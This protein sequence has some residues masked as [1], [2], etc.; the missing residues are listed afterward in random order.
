M[1]SYGIHA[2]QLQGNAETASNQGYRDTMRAHNQSVMA[3]YK[4]T[5]DKLSTGED[6]GKGEFG[7]LTAY[8]SLSGIHAGYQAYQLYQKHGSFA[9]AL[10]TGT[11]HNI[12]DLSGGK[13]GKLPMGP[14]EASTRSFADAHLGG[15]LDTLAQGQI[16]AS[17]A[18]DQAAGWTR[19]SDPSKTTGQITADVAKTYGKSDENL[20]LEGKMIKGVGKMV[21]GEDLEKVGHLAG[22][23]APIVSGV[24]S[25]VLGAVDMA[26]NWKKDDTGQK[27]G[28]VLGEVGSVLDAA[29]AVAP[30]LAPLAGLASAAGAISDLVGGI[31]ASNKSK[32]D[33]GSAKDE[34]TSAVPQQHDSYVQS[35][36]TTSMG[37]TSLQKLSGGSS[38]Y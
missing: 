18:T 35:S 34:A 21:G 24:A 3:E 25:G 7:G 19:A 23:V 1:D 2:A 5:M 6:I 30:I 33:A 17:Q 13:Y 11:Q 32:A 14:E 22:S 9:G 26:E 36:T 29:S 16:K 4:G 27:A 20:S 37:P 31:Q 10:T 8:S 12:Y 15:N 38:S 28:A